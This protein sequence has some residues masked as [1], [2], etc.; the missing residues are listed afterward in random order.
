MLVFVASLVSFL[1]LTYLV[2]IGATRGF[3]L[4]LGH[5]VQS[6][7][8]LKQISDTVM[9]SG[10]GPWLYLWTGA[11]FL[12]F[13]LTKRFLAAGIFIL[14][15]AIDTFTFFSLA[16]LINRP[17]PTSAELFVV[18]PLNIGG[19]PSGHVLLVSMVFLFLMVVVQKP[20]VII[21]GI[22]LM[23]ITGIGRIYSG[24]HF[25]T[26]IIGAYLLAPVLI[27]PLK[28]LYFWLIKLWSL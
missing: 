13:I 24:Q 14:L 27:I 19:Y 18:F 25:P 26:D 16:N 23:A 20:W 3:D 6:F 15:Y 17:R 12:F 10:W 5:F 28:N 4:A 9:Y 22:T 1:V 11:V 8:F 2:K 7:T 21:L